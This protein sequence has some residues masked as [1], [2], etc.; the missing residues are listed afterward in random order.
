[1]SW[2]HCRL[3]TILLVRHSR[4][5]SVRFRLFGILILVAVRI[6][7]DSAS[8]SP[9]LLAATVR[10]PRRA[11]AF[12]TETVA[13]QPA[14]MAAS[15]ST[16]EMSQAKF[17]VSMADST[18]GG[19]KGSPRKLARAKLLAKSRGSGGD[20]DDSENEELASPRGIGAT[21]GASVKRPERV[22]KPS[23]LNA[24]YPGLDEST[25]VTAVNDLVPLDHSAIQ[26][27]VEGI[28]GKDPSLAHDRNVIRFVQTR[29]FSHMSVGLFWLSAMRCKLIAFEGSAQD[30]LLRGEN[31]SLLQQ[32][33][34][35]IQEGMEI[36]E[37][38]GFELAAVAY[39]STFGR[40]MARQGV[41]VDSAIT[42]RDSLF[43]RLPIL[44]SKTVY[45]LLTL[46]FSSA[47]DHAVFAAPV[48]ED[49]LTRVS[50]WV[51]GVEPQN[52]YIQATTQWPIYSRRKEAKQ[53]TSFDADALTR[54]LDE[55]STSVFNHVQSM[56][57]LNFEFGSSTTVMPRRFKGDDTASLGRASSIRRG[58]ASAKATG[59]APSLASLGGGIGA[60]SDRSS[61]RD[62]ASAVGAA[63]PTAVRLRS[64]VPTL[65]DGIRWYEQG[66]MRGS[67]SVDRV[68]EAST[69][70]QLWSISANSPLIRH[71]LDRMQISPF[72]KGHAG[73]PMMWTS[74]TPLDRR[75]TT[76]KFGT[77]ARPVEKKASAYGREDRRVQDAIIDR[78]RRD[79]VAA[80]RAMR[81]N[82][83]KAKLAALHVR[84]V[85]SIH[86]SRTQEIYNSLRAR[87]LHAIQK[88]H[89][90]GD[91][92]ITEVI[93]LANGIITD[94]ADHVHDLPY[95][96]RGE[97]QR[98]S[99]VC[100]RG[101]H[102]LN[103]FHKIVMEEAAQK[104]HLAY[105][106]VSDVGALALARMFEGAERGVPADDVELVHLLKDACETATNAHAALRPASA[107][108][109]DDAETITSS[110]P[111]YPS[112]T[113]SGA[114]T[115]DWIVLPGDG[116]EMNEADLTKRPYVVS[117]MGPPVDSEAPS[118]QKRLMHRAPDDLIELTGLPLAEGGNSLREPLGTAF[119][120][121][122]R[123]SFVS[124]PGVVL[125]SG[126]SYAQRQA[127]VFAKLDD[128]ATAMPSTARPR[129]RRPSPTPAEI[130][131]SMAPTPPATAR[132]A[133]HVG[134]PVNRTSDAAWTLAREP[135]VDRARPVSVSVWRDCSEDVDRYSPDVSISIPGPLVHTPYHTERSSRA[136]P[137]AV[138]RAASHA[139]AVTSPTVRPDELAE[140]SA[141]PIEPRLRVTGKHHTVRQT[142]DPSD[143]SAGSEEPPRSTPRVLPPRTR[144]P[145]QPWWQPPV[146][147]T[148]V[149]VACSDSMR[150]PETSPSFQRSTTARTLK[151]SGVANAKVSVERQVAMATAAAATSPAI[152]LLPSINAALLRRA[153][154]TVSGSPSSRPAAR[155]ANAEAGG[156]PLGVSVKA[157]PPKRSPRRGP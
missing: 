26:A 115:D 114:A 45:Y 25:G 85:H 110:S 111:Q 128:F 61:M 144:S 54:T 63:S 11:P 16:M 10:S 139:P 100:F 4:Q 65:H 87:L 81:F 124:A 150:R 74:L 82:T 71:Y 72:D 57:A 140:K 131:S 14:A 49:I 91:A 68:S 21:V 89:R 41:S 67:L 13:T 47:A 48:R 50:K 15:A 93:T 5:R 106:S 92:H 37:R 134:A 79:V 130:L 101:V 105:Y 9:D 109:A 73:Q 43:Q 147:G 40:M 60:T 66:G 88:A 58:K 31:P 27:V 90:R 146:E 44:V 151:T 77:H 148:A 80:Q 119:H 136:S 2:R 103:R 29:E 157:E 127:E 133:N 19:V 129:G 7:M 120:G 18:G 118:P 78:E 69:P 107:G 34:C 122:Q 145:P 113:E 64:V 38:N 70:R 143:Q 86:N 156:S 116:V 33:R 102:R 55:A 99:L 135:P 155:P 36:S 42:I 137:S 95:P 94:V 75:G 6:T 62:T 28:I 98:L 24:E 32:Q 23:L 20:S 83:G 123:G 138:S 141:A 39:G 3:H 35:D 53:T 17:S 51:T 8:S 126:A 46:V 96:A 117:V 52:A 1:V 30:R 22:V 125:P 132:P 12:M 76:M 152:S 97:L 154:A 142:L 153:V 104:E 84:A 121:S 56:R 108:S 59:N 112:T 149:V